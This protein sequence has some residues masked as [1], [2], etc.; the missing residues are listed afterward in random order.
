MQRLTA[1]YQESMYIG[2]KIRSIGGN[3]TQP[4]KGNSDM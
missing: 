1:F 4:A 3:D 2:N